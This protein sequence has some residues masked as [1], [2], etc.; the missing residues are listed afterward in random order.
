MRALLWLFQAKGQIFSPEPTDGATPTNQGPALAMEVKRL[1]A[2]L[3]LANEKLLVSVHWPQSYCLVWAFLCP[4]RFFSLCAALPLVD[5]L[6]ASFCTPQQGE[7]Q[8]TK[9]L[10]DWRDEALA[11]EGMRPPVSVHWPQ[12]H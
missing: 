3:A 8:K 2:E 11:A 1:S 9:R 10:W 5:H 12:S 7:T 6:S 4:A